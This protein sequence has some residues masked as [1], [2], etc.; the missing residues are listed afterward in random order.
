MRI[1]TFTRHHRLAKLAAALIAGYLFCTY[2]LQNGTEFVQ[3]ECEVV[4]PNTIF[5]VSS[6]NHSKSFRFWRMPG[7]EKTLLDDDAYSTPDNIAESLKRIANMHKMSSVNCHAL[8]NDVQRDIEHAKRTNEKIR[9]PLDDC[10]YLP[11]TVD[12][13]TFVASRGYILSPLTEE[14]EE[15]PLS[16]SVLAY[17]DVEM[18]ERL[19]KAI[20]SPQNYYCIH[21]DE[22]S[23]HSFYQSV[24]SIAKCFPNVFIAS[25]RIDVRWGWF[26]VLEPELQCMKELWRYPK[27]KYFFTLTGQEFPLKTNFE[28]VKILTVYDGANDIEGTIRKDFVGYILHNKTAKEILHWAKTYTFV[29]DET[30]FATLN[31]NPQLGIRGAYKGEPETDDV[32]NPFLTRFKNWGRFQCA[33]GQFVRNICILTLGNNYYYFVFF[34]LKLYYQTSKITIMCPLHN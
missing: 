4:E 11:L 29:P 15:F 24:A 34:F 10:S 32:I 13:R 6:L 8:F 21:I 7:S 14:E 27:W 23:P 18:V 3:S 31:Y 9:T 16:F 30:Y 28:L 5:S 33:S 26:S 19:L 17:K 1:C 2:V 20:Y 22:K 25:R 12:C